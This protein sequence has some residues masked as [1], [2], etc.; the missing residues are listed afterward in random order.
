MKTGVTLYAVI[1]ALL[2][3]VLI[4]LIVWASVEKHVLEIFRVMLAERWGIV[5][6]IDLYA[7]SSSRRHGSACWNG[8]RGGR[9][10]G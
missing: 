8:V 4:A 6:L 3:V 5:T 2:A 9:C 7:G 10:H 1:F